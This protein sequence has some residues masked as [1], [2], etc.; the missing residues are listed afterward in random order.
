M[1]TNEILENNEL[2][3]EFMDITIGNYTTEEEE[4]PTQYHINDILFHYSWDWL[5]PVVEK[6]MKT[7]DN[8]NRFN[9][10]FNALSTVDIE[11]VYKAV[12]YFIEWYNE[13][14]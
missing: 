6:C 7:G 14:E 10:I 13:N 11:E 9:D 4:A 5:M 3:A 12:I 1:K 8:P 2:I